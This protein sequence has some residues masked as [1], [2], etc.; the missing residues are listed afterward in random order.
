MLVEL[1]GTVVR[2]LDAVFVTDWFSE[3]DE[4]LDTSRADPGISP[5]GDVL[6]Q[7][8]PSGPAFATE[9]NLALFNSLIYRAER[10]VSITSPYFVPE[11]SLL[12]AI[13]T[14]ARR[15]VQVELFVG[16]I[17]D[18]FLVFHAQHSY[19]QDLLEAGVRIYLYPAPNI[20]HAK[21][22]SIDDDVAVIGSSNMD[23]RSFQLD[24]EVMVLLSGR[25][26]TDELRAVEDE[27]RRLSRELTRTECAQRSRRHRLVDDLARLTSAVQ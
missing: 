8:A 10:R 1:R 18:Q 15:G 23:I 3:T 26:V 20:L 7:V 19:Y 17:G 4:L 13:A 5:V 25:E 11:E 16:E 22:L 2:S 27:Y 24:P 9:N 21:H 6:A 12:A 14:A